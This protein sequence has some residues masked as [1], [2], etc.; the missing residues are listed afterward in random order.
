MAKN[1]KNSKTQPKKVTIDDQS[2]Y[3]GNGL[4]NKY[5]VETKKQ[6]EL[7]KQALKNNDNEIARSASRNA[8]NSIV[9]ADIY[10]NQ[11]KSITKM[12]SQLINE[13]VELYQKTKLLVKSI[14]GDER[15][16]LSEDSIAGDD[17]YGRI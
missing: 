3:S 13:V 12:D 2:I 5:I 14:Y 1:K 16:I 17:F 9:D 7:A 10:I 8:L 11:H 6:T 4:L 15:P